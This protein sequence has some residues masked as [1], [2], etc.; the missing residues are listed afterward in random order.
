MT[1][2][3]GGWMAG[4]AMAIL[5]TLALTFIVIQPRLQPIVRRYFDAEVPGALLAVPISIG[6]GLVW[7]MLGLAFGSVYVLG[8][9]D[10]TAGALGAPSWQWLVL[11]ATIAVLPVPVLLILSTRLWWLWAGMSAAFLGLFGW[12]MPVLAE[13]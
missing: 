6:T 1:A 5:S 3:L 11:I 8:D 2:V 9:F 7:T 10:A 4:Y 12:L 13:R